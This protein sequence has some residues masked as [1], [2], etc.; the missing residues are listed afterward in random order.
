MQAKSM[1]NQKLYDNESSDLRKS[2]EKGKASD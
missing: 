2:I 1:D